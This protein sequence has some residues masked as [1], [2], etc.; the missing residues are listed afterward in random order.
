VAAIAVAIG[1]IPLVGWQI[2]VVTVI[3]P[4]LLI[5][6]ANDYG[7]HIIARFQEDGAR[8][9]N[10]DASQLAQ[11]GIRQLAKPVLV[12]G[13][14]TI[15]G[16]LCLLVHVLVSAK[17]MGV[18]AAAGVG[19]ALLASLFFIPA[20]LTVLPLP[21]PRKKGAQGVDSKASLL[22]RMLRAVAM[23]VTRRPGLTIIATA[24]VTAMIAAGIPLVRVDT[25]SVNYYPADSEVVRTANL[26]NDKFGGLFSISAI[27]EGDI[28]SPE[29]MRA[30]DAFSTYLKAHPNVDITT[31]IAEVIRDMNEVIHD[32][33]ATYDTIPETRDAIAQYFLVYSASGDPE[34]FDRLVD[35]P[36]AHA[37]LSARINENSTGAIKSVVDY[38]N[39][40]VDAHPNGPFKR[41]GGIGAVFAEM[42]SHVVHGQA[43]SLVLSMLVVAL[44]VGLLFRSPAAGIL[45]AIPLGLAMC[46]LFGLMGYLGVEL[47]VATAMLSS[48]MI[49][50]GVDYTI[51][52]LWRYRQ[53]RQT[54]VVPVV[55]VER[56]LSSTGRG[57]V[58]NALSVIFGF[59]VLMISSFLP[60][61][62]FGFLV[63]VSIAACLL[64]T[65]V[66]LPPILVV[67]KPKFA[68]PKTQTDNGRFS[69]RAVAVQ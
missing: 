28:K 49:G 34:D 17:Q 51:H 52:L 62:F 56:T 67:L 54:G 18:L 40:Y 50:V 3:L 4:V 53:E 41:V 12:T 24:A 31:S 35:F 30:I 47:N 58:F 13:I 5:A 16:L 7:I 33:D 64:G 55:A 2:K 46:L 1:L 45:S 15:A 23:G 11:K 6:V 19:F 10:A 63:V 68:E 42:V 29:T 8:D 48:I 66:L 65:L 59:S 37:N 44:L 36:Y 61:R 60:V 22:I 26:V 57:I 43:L 69:R 38:A 14:T 25:N 20:V 39:A 32:G 9:R 21:K 27:A